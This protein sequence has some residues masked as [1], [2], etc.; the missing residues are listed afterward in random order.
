M[1]TL[2]LI[3]K[4]QLTFV[5]LPRSQGGGFVVGV[6]ADVAG[7]DFPGYVDCY[8]GDLWTVEGYLHQTVKGKTLFNA[9]NEWV[10]LYG[11]TK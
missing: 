4:Y 7:I 8:E 5:S 1:D 2:N 3:E 6:F 9:V 11:N 10:K